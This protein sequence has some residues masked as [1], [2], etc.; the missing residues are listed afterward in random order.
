MMAVSE[1]MP[2]AYRWWLLEHL[3]SFQEAGRLV[4]IM[5]K[6]WVG[7]AREAAEA[8]PE[9]AL[10]EIA[11]AAEE[12]GLPVEKVGAVVWLDPDCGHPSLR[13]CLTVPRKIPWQVANRK[14]A[15]LCFRLSE[16]G[17]FFRSIVKFLT[18]SRELETEG[19]YVGRVLEVKRMGQEG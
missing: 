6:A 19:E 13:I 4:D 16:R 3:R 1:E 9:E 12:V 10:K 5:E 18:W 11:E 15:E 8:F 14:F 2:P 17:A 7:I